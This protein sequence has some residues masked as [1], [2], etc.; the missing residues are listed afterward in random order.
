MSSVALSPK[1]IE[2]P[3]SSSISP[4]MNGLL[5][6]FPQSRVKT[7]SISC[8]I[9][10]LKLSWLSDAAMNCNGVRQVNTWKGDIDATQIVGWWGCMCNLRAK[11]EI[12]NKFPLLMVAQWDLGAG[13]IV[14]WG[15][16][17][18]DLDSRVLVVLLTD[19]ARDTPSLIFGYSYIWLGRLCLPGTIFLFE[20]HLP[21]QDQNI[22]QPIGTKARLPRLM[23]N[24]ASTSAN[25]SFY[26]INVTHTNA[27]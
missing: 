22:W 8:W 15:G 20:C 12:S 6:S 2:I 7:Q 23:R 10:K 1:K 14:S 4:T 18:K 11:V 17:S 9:V 24:R 13:K 27:M 21:E 19:V 25:T 3:S 16:I 5:T 26:D